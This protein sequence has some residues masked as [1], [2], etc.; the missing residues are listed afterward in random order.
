MKKVLIIDDDHFFHQVIKSQLETQDLKCHTC[1][2]YAAAREWIATQGTPDIILL[3]YDLGPGQKSG[4]DICRQIKETMS[5]PVIMVSG[6]ERLQT[7]VACLDAGA[8]QYILKPYALE[9]LLARMRAAFRLYD[10]TVAEPAEP[11]LNAG[12]ISLNTQSG[13]LTIGDA[14]VRLTDMEV[15]VTRLLLQ[16]F[17]A[18]TDRDELCQT[19]YGRNFDP[20]NR[21]LDVLVGRLRKKIASISAGYA[22]K[23]V[24]GKGYRLHPTTGRR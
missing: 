2:T 13:D 4:I 3:D 16:H 14:A 1:K 18:L 20:A 10:R 19:L 23:N 22:I 8:D 9:E 24:R 5:L 12:A 21:S 6:D 7:I 15:A 17:G 11:I